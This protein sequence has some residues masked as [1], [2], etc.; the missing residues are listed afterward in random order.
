MYL[1]E[2]PQSDAGKNPLAVSEPTIGST[3]SALQ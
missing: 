1:I 2:T 3:I